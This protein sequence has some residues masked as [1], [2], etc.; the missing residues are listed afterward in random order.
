M[1]VYAASIFRNEVSIYIHGYVKKTMAGGSGD[2]WP[3]CAKRER[4]WKIV[5]GRVNTNC[6]QSNGARRGL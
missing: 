3:D 5:Q 1:E 4:A 2:R 6:W